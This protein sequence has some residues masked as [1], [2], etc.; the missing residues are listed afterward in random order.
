MVDR[1][2]LLL[3]SPLA[4]N[5]NRNVKRRLLTPAVLP[6]KINATLLDTLLDSPLP[7]IMRA[8]RPGSLVGLLPQN[9]PGPQDFQ[10]QTS[11]TLPC[12]LP[13]GLLVNTLLSLCCH[14]A[15]KVLS[16]CCHSAVT[17]T[18]LL[19]MLGKDHVERR[20]H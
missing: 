13:L 8:T 17:L 7:R 10:N 4:G 18:A 12:L 3:R 20:I 16:F 5:F 6:R 14:S 11:T 15:V 9:S 19:P 1:V 2:G